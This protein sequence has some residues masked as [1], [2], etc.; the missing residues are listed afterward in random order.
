MTLVSVWYLLPWITDGLKVKTVTVKY[1][2]LIPEKS[3]NIGVESILWLIMVW[4]QDLVANSISYIII[5]QF[6]EQPVGACWVERKAEEK[7]GVPACSFTPAVSSFLKANYC[8]LCSNDLQH[9]LIVLMLTSWCKARSSGW[10]FCQAR[11][12]PNTHNIH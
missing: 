3:L 11:K 8:A 10:F 2:C 9:F 12:S 1:Q 6:Q 5:L 7:A 4:N